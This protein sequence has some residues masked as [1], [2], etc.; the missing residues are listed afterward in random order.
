MTDGSIRRQLAWRVALWAVVGFVILGLGVYASIAASIAADQREEMDNRVRIIA[1]IVAQHAHR[2]PEAVAE[3]L[4]FYAPRRP[5]TH[6]RLHDERSGRLLHDDPPVPPWRLSPDRRTLPVRIDVPGGAFGPLIGDFAQDIAT[7]RGALQRVALLLGLATLAAGALVAAGAAWQ[8]RRALRPLAV[9]ADRTRRLTPGHSG[10]RLSL[11]TVPVELEPWITQFN[12]LLDRNE[13]AYMQLESF[14]ADVA[15]ELRTPLATLIGETEL[16]LARDRPAEDLRETLH[17][18]LEELHRLRGIVNDML[19]LSRADRGAEARREPVARVAL[20]AAEVVDF[21]EAAI[22][23]AGVRVDIDG[24]AAFELDAALVKR[25]LS[26]LLGNALRFA[27]R[28]STVRIHIS[29]APDES[30]ALAVDNAGPPIAD[31]DA[32]RIFERFYR[33]GAGRER[34]AGH[35]LGLAIVAAI[36]RMHGGSV[37]TESRQDGTR[38]GLVLG[39][40]E[41]ARSRR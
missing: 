24:D 34:G 38:V 28:G 23:D 27:E 3:R 18:N 33:G 11:D 8:A 35:G 17:S 5:G 19:F 31:E 41:P 20:V 36:A 15:H 25:A 40:A 4:A 12:A 37:F 14:N 39:S 30:L 6:L 1:G 22:D 32:S 26:N 10:E 13:S 21:H 2:G 29:L 7:D 9:L 16:A